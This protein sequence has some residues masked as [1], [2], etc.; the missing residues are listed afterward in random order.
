MSH[1][2]FFSFSIQLLASYPVLGNGDEEQEG[3]IKRDHYLNDCVHRNVKIRDYT[4]LTSG[5]LFIKGESTID[6]RF[7]NFF[8]WQIMYSNS[9]FVV[10]SLLFFISTYFLM[11][12]EQEGMLRKI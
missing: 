12:S 7:Y 6:T 4:K 10:P 9:N 2:L 5:V 3:G 8:V 11:S 1:S